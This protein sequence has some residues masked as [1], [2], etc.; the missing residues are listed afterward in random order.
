[1][2]K[3]KRM[4][5]GSI[6]TEK[7]QHTQINRSFMEIYYSNCLRQKRLLG[8]MA[9]I[10]ANLKW[11]TFDS[12]NRVEIAPYIEDSIAISRFPLLCDD[13]DKFGAQVKISP[14]GNFY[15]SS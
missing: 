12:V 8:H 15:W 5:K 9:I 4:K 13:L 14:G 3:E 7:S 10:Y 11:L 2:V 6:S 1:M